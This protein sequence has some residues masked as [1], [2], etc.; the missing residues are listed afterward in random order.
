MKKLFCF[1]NQNIE[2]ILNRISNKKEYFNVIAKGLIVTTLILFLIYV[3]VLA[4]EANALWLFLRFGFVLFAL[5]VTMLIFNWVLGRLN[6]FS[7]L[8]RFSLLVSFPLLYVVS[9][10][11]I[12]LS[13]FLLGLILLGFSLFYTFRKNQL[14]KFTLIKKALTF[15]GAT[16]FL[17]CFIGLLGLYYIDGFEQ[18]K[19]RNATLLS[20]TNIKHIKKPSPAEIGP[21]K[22]KRFTYG[23]GKDKHREAY[24][25]GANIKTPSVDCDK[26]I[27]NW[28]GIN[29]W[30]RT[31][32]WGFDQTELPLNG[33]VWYPDFDG[34]FPLVLIVHGDHAMQDY[35]DEGYAYLGELL[36]SRG[37]IVAS[38]D[39]NFLNIVWS[40]KT[41][42]LFEENDARA[43]LLLE[44]LKLWHTWNSEKENTFYNKID[45]NNIALV[46]HSRGGESVAH[47]ALFN[48]LP[49]YPDNASIVFDYNFNIKS[50]IAIGAVDGQ[51]RPSKSKTRLKDINYLT[52]H[53]SYDG[54]VR[55]FVSL[56]QF[57]R[58][59]FTDTSYYFKSAVYI[60]GA[61]HGQF[62]T[63]WGNKDSFSPFS[64]LLNL[65]Y[66]LRVEDQ[67]K[68]A[69]VY[70]SAF[71]DASLKNTK[72]YLPLF[73][74]YRAGQ[75][76]LPNTIYLSDFQDSNSQYLCTFD[77]DFD[78]S[79]TTLR[80]GKI[81]TTNMT[82]WK[83]QNGNLILGWDKELK[84]SSENDAS[85]KIEVPE[86]SIRLDSS[87]N[88]IFSIMPLNDHRSEPDGNKF[89]ST[90]G[91][92]EFSIVLTDDLGEKVSF[93]S[94]EF[95]FPQEKFDVAI[96]KIDF[97][98][99]KL[100]PKNM[101]QYFSYSFSE[102]KKL[103]ENFNP[104][105]VKDIYFVFDKTKQGTIM[106]DDIG[107][108][109]SFS[110]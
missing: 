92:I 108:T 104:T 70:I 105:R 58:V 38:I 99:N 83:E 1:I 13:L 19:L 75:D 106:I 2:L 17:F 76:W 42:A 52:M 55:N 45:T 3:S 27:Q 110:D 10:K 68:I 100:R 103:N 73:T 84:S 54:E 57:D 86:N 51:Y 36:A 50:L 94:S 6:Y 88:F 33:R 28:N 59:K 109:K 47:A 96:R 31:K 79:T 101:L 65:R 62:N 72:A 63:S 90:N 98:E 24:G 69:K 22:V 67:Q 8:F 15:L 46:G 85:F 16:L 60:H 4:Y 61:N 82:K 34:V 29:G 14:V 81:S 89:E 78:L 25:E 9:D 12:A 80:N 95:S 18:P 91:L 107:F 41:G 87:S 102:M 30:W 64:K 44:H 5:L 66:L 23:S 35:S 48:R 39:E 37:Y 11:S 97:L 40:Y 7:K 74:D 56:D 71:L 26:F 32:Y 20:G 43:I 21:F 49:Y 77:E 53:G 93:L